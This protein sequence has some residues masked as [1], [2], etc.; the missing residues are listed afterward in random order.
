MSAV[1]PFRK[2]SRGGRTQESE[3]QSMEVLGRVVSSVAHDFNN[4]ITG[5]LLYSDLLAKELPLDSR[6]QKHA[7]GIRRAGE[8]GA[9]L[10]QQL[11]SVAKP[12]IEETGLLSMSSVIAEM[13][14]LL[15][16][17]VGE[18]IEFI[19]QEEPGLGHVRMAS[20]Q[21][22][23]I[24]LNLVLNAR[25]AISDGGRITLEARSVQKTSNIE[26][27]VRDSGCG[28][29]ADVR[30]Q[31]FQPFFTTKKSGNGTGL[32]LF[33]VRNIV[34]QSGGTL[35][36]Q[37]EAGKG[38]RVIIRLPKAKQNHNAKKGRGNLV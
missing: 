2:V 37:S 21:L 12:Q 10:I 25:D 7:A 36:V 34:A 23:R 19:I 31:L 29:N 3:S 15:A 16:R 27:I 30:A 4:L 8:N 5:V 22:Q 18:N 32:G 20:S 9:A 6:L 11:L 1:V 26:I 13:R 33:T 35:L 17:L 24:L 14:D 28:M 38:T